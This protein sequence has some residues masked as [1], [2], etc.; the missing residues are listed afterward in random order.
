[1]MLFGL[2]FFN[3]TISFL[4]FLSCKLSIITHFSLPS[5]LDQHH[6]KVLKIVEFNPFL[7]PPQSGDSSWL[8]A[9]SGWKLVWCHE[10]I[11]HLCHTLF[12][13]VREWR[14]LTSPGWAEG[15]RVKNSSLRKLWCVTATWKLLDVERSSKE[16]RKK[17]IGEKKASLI[18]GVLII[19]VQHSGT[20]WQFLLSAT[21]FIMSSGK[22]LWAFHEPQSP[23]SKW[24][25]PLSYP[26]S[27][28]QE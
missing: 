21:H 27:Y 22:A 13:L 10:W 28:F 7:L 11:P 1:M 14:S 26:S 12:D 17:L 20:G 9:E 3:P 25:I 15:G 16:I 2:K 4:P 23:F 8:G 6:F 24:I 18:T 5:K 19:R